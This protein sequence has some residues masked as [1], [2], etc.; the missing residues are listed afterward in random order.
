MATR[1]EDPRPEA[2]HRRRYWQRL[3]LPVVPDRP[4][5]RIENV[6]AAADCGA[7]GTY[8]R[9]G[10][11]SWTFMNAHLVVALPRP[12]ASDSRGLECDGPLRPTGAAQPV[13]QEERRVGHEDGRT[14]STR[15]APRRQEKKT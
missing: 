7:G 10:L 2:P 11:R 8:A 13:G 4:L 12:P 6:L 3:L 5:S 1:W 9:L 15:W 14:G